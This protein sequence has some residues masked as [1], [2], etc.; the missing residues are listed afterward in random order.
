M[1]TA[2]SAGFICRTYSAALPQPETG[3][4]RVVW[5]NLLCL[6][7]LRLVVC[8]RLYLCCHAWQLV[9]YQLRIVRN[10]RRI[11]HDDDDDYY[12]YIA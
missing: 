5:S 3:K 10:K 2:R 11:H 4:Q 8:V 6:V 1:R 7:V 9:V 12:Y